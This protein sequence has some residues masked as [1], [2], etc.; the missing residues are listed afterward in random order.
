MC[1]YNTLKI[2][3]RYRPKIYIIEN[4]AYS[5]IWDYIKEVIGFNIPHENLTYYNNYDYP[6]KKPTKF[7]SNIDLKL[8]K[9]DI[10]NTIKFN[11]LNITGVNRYNTRSNIPLQLI[12]DILTRCDHYITRE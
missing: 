3:E 8:L 12:K 4:P 10:R 9:D 2:I 5:R 11:K 6:I 1:I 7:G